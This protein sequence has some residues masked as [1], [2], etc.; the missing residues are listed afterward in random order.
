MLFSW[1]IRLQVA[2]NRNNYS[3]GVANA[4]RS[5]VHTRSLP[6]AYNPWFF[7]NSRIVSPV[8][9]FS[10]RPLPCRVSTPPPRFHFALSQNRLSLGTRVNKSV[11]CST[12]AGIPILPSRILS[13]INERIIIIVT[14]R[15]SA[16][17][18]CLKKS[19]LYSENCKIIAHPPRVAT[20][21]CRVYRFFS[22]CNNCVIT[23]ASAT[24]FDGR[25]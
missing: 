15:N 25:R 4:L 24:P 2:V 22:L 16:D 8:R 18:I 1:E 11:T 13:T 20:T 23:V 10:G 5:T 9:R 7:Q 6:N 12:C 14:S 17:R 3:R 19:C 21:P